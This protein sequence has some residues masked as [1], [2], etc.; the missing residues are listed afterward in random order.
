MDLERAGLRQRDQAIDVFDGDRLVAVRLW[1]QS[2]KSGFDAG[3]GVFLEKTLPGGALRAPHDRD[4]PRH[5]MWRHPLPDPG[6]IIGEI[7]LGHASIFPIDPV[8]MGEANTA[9]H[10]F[11]FGFV[12]VFG[13]RR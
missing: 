12:G 13:R 3:R 8:G 1:H 9:R 4:N 10:L 7:A 6:V 2:E 11:G 5:E